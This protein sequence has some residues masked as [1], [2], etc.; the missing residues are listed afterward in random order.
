M[1]QPTNKQTKKCLQTIAKASFQNRRTPNV[2]SAVS[3]CYS[4]WI[5]FWFRLLP[6]DLVVKS[7][8]RS[9]DLTTRSTGRRRN[10]N[11]IQKL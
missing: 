1:N 6:V 8:D 5:R 7:I 9:I 4:F 11:R 3:E 10:Q 2:L